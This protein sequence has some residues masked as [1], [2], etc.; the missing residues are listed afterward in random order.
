[1]CEY[2]CELIFGVYDEGGVVCEWFCEV[3]V[4][5]VELEFGEM[6]VVG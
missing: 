6:G 3:F 2:G 1:M 4:L 5:W